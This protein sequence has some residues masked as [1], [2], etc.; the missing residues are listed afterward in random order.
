MKILKFIGFVVLS[1]CIFLCPANLAN[2]KEVGKNVESNVQISDPQTLKKITILKTLEKENLILTEV[3]K[4]ATN[5]KEDVLCIALN[6]YHEARG[7]SVKDQIASTYVVFNRYANKNY[8]LTLPQEERSLC[9][10]VFDKWQFCWTNNKIIPKPRVKNKIEALAWENA[11]KLALELYTNPIHKELA[12]EFKLQH[13]VVT[14]LLYDK[15][16]PKWI[17]KRQMTIQI[18]KH[19]YMSLKENIK[20]TKLNREKYVNVINRAHYIIFGK[21]DDKVVPTMKKIK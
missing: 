5:K 16:R 10:I 2:S 21:L 4:L 9:N 20:N 18:G 19:S 1:L 7:S 12:K 11:Q 3:K 13:Y 17:D 14:P 8:P 6:M 15:A